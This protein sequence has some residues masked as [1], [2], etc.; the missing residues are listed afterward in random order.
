[1]VESNPEGVV[2]KSKQDEAINW[3]NQGNILAKQGYFE[4]ALFAYNKGLELDP[5]N[6]DILH[7]RAVILTKYGRTKEIQNKHLPLEATFFI[8]WIDVKVVTYFPAETPEDVIEQIAD[9]I[10]LIIYNTRCFVVENR[11]LGFVNDYLSLD[12]VSGYNIGKGGE[13]TITPVI[14]DI[15]SRTQAHDIKIS[16]PFLHFIEKS[17]PEIY[18][19]SMR[20]RIIF[21]PVPPSGDSPLYSCANLNHDMYILAAAS[22]LI[23]TRYKIPIGQENGYSPIIVDGIPCI[24]QHQHLIITTYPVLYRLM[25][26]E[27]DPILAELDT[28]CLGDGKQ[29]V[30]QLIKWLRSKG[31]PPEW[32]QIVDGYLENGRLKESLKTEQMR[33]PKTDIEE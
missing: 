33:I 23:C 9:D 4:S 2:T 25:N 28:K 29:N 3:K 20:W 18:P 11:S 30:Y 26:F 24:E 14:A 1:M 19:D 16:R 10:E 22:N 8:K 27:Y 13:I 6:K 32:A 15:N 5:T 21:R 31:L 7:N 17:N 12:F